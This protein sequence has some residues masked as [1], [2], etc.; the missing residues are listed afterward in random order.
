MEKQADTFGTRILV[1]SG[2]AADGIHNLMAKLA[3]SNQDQDNPE[4]PAW[5][6]SHPNTKQR[7]EYMEELIVDNNLNRYQYE[8]VARHQEV[9]TL[10]TSKWQDYEKC[11]KDL[12]VEDLEQAKECAGNKQP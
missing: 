6:S 10:V 1:N 2:Y 8:G 3:Q 9:K 11:I 5:L 7:I 12:E 4:P